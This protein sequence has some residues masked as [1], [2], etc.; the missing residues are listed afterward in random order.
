MDKEATLIFLLFP[1]LAYLLGSVPFGLLIGRARGVDIRRAGSGNIGA[2]NVGRLLGRKWGFI[3]FLLDVAKG[4][5]PVLLTSLYLRRSES[6]VVEG[7]LSVGAQGAL[8]AVGAGCILGHIFSLY[9]KFRGGKGVATSLGVVLGVW[10]YFTLTALMALCVWLAVWGW[11]RYV[12]L[13]SICAAVGFPAGF[14]LLIWRI[15]NWYFNSLWPL[16]SFSC[17]M[18]VLVILRHRANVKRLLTGAENR[19]GSKGV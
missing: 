4:L 11:W 2:T 14:I 13:A 6:T 10:P 19:G 16:F 18:A 3:C 7:G 1:V 15:D 12:S 5:I 9:L 8:L 17:L